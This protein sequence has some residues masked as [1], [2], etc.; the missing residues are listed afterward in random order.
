MIKGLEEKELMKKMVSST[1]QKVTLSEQTDLS[2][3]T[4]C[5]LMYISVP[6]FNEYM[7]TLSPNI[8]LSDL[9]KHVEYIAK[10]IN[11]EGGEIDKIMAEKQL[12]AFHT[13]NRNKND[14]I[15]AACKAAKSI[16]ELEQQNMLPFSIAIGISCGTV[17]T[18]FLGVGDKRDFTVIGDP[19]NV[20]AR[21]AAYGEKQETN[22]YL[23]SEE[24]YSIAKTTIKGDY[25]GE[26]SLKGKSQPM[27]LYSIS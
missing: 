7:K 2:K 27:K 18:G 22:K 8:V 25:A 9:Q 11:H 3:K 12:I 15:K 23:V 5:I 1:A 24:I 17:V 6:D 20:A 26:I 14:C 10:A 21:I 13:E 4:E 16:I 19:V